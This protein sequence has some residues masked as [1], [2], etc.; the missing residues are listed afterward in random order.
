MHNKHI[1]VN[2]FIGRRQSSVA[3]RIRVSERSPGTNNVKFRSRDNILMRN[4]IEHTSCGYWSDWRSF[5]NFFGPRQPTTYAKKRRSTKCLGDVTTATLANLSGNIFCCFDLSC[6]EL[7][8]TIA[9]VRVSGLTVAQ[10]LR[11]GRVRCGQPVL[12]L[13]TVGRCW[14]AAHLFDCLTLNHVCSARRPTSLC[15]CWVAMRAPDSLKGKDG[16][17]SL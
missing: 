2:L 10:T 14:S 17:R 15:S 8:P 9:K 4:D 16:A 7:T 11:G 3:F 13:P 5:R 1:A 6:R 12:H